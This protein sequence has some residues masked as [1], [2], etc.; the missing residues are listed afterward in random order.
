MSLQGQLDMLSGVEP[1]GLLD[2]LKRRIHRL[3]LYESH[4]HSEKF[5]REHIK[6]IEKFLTRGGNAGVASAEN[7]VT[8]MLGFVFPRVIKAQQAHA[9]PPTNRNLRLEDV[10]DGVILHAHFESEIAD[11]EL[12]DVF[13]RSIEDYWRG[14]FSWEGKTLNFKVSQ[15]V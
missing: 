6:D 4:G 1:E 9:P 8:R 5:V 14:K 12:L 10:K 7:W 13:K 2:G 3:H 15:R 11:Q